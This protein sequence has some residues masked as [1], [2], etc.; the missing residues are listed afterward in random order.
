M[1]QETRDG[2]IGQLIREE[3][4]TPSLK[5]VW[6]SGRFTL[7][8]T[9]SLPGNIAP[10]RRTSYRKIKSSWCRLLRSSSLK[11]RLWRQW[12]QSR[13]TTPSMPS[14]KARWDL[15][16]HRRV[17]M[18]QPSGTQKGEDPSLRNWSCMV[19]LLTTTTHWLFN[20]SKLSSTA[21]SREPRSLPSQRQARR[22]G[23]DKEPICDTLI[24]T[25]SGLL[26][27]KSL[28]RNSSDSVN[29]SFTLGTTLYSVGYL[30]LLQRRLRMSK[31]SR[32]H[33]KHP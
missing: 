4:R 15:I 7:R 6:I 9:F 29:S 5:L 13:L 30:F 20:R 14:T 10:R 33:C 32:W 3:L 2:K 27:G 8:E 28:E 11:V 21:F 12:C 17:T 23:L 26:I 22:R 16:T 31:A 19:N 24:L 1:I 18:L 25:I